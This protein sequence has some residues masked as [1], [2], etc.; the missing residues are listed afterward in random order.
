MKIP[1]VEIKL[2]DFLVLEEKKEA[3]GEVVFWEDVLGHNIQLSLLFFVQLSDTSSLKPNV[4]TS[5]KRHCT[6]FLPSFSA[7]SSPQNP[8]QMPIPT[9]INPSLSNPFPT[10]LEPNLLHPK[11]PSPNPNPNPESL[12]EQI[13]PQADQGT[14]TWNRD[15]MRYIEDAPVIFPISYPS[16]VVP[17]PEDRVKEDEDGSKNERKMIDDDRWNAIMTRRRVLGE[18]QDDDHVEFPTLIKGSG[19]ASGGFQARRRFSGDD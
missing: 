19:V 12:P 6:T 11:K 15:K 14:R 10:Q 5:P 17:L 9:S 13:P 4:I 8:T 16:R 3:Q 7:A 18:E 1:G 2:A